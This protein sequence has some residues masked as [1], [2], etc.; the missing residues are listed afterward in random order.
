VPRR[1]LLLLGADN[2]DA[3]A[4]K[5][6]AR[7]KV[8][9]FGLSD[10]CDWRGYDLQVS[11]LSTRFGVRRSGQTIGTFE[12]PLLG[13]YN[14]RNALA[15]MAVGAAVGLS[16]ETMADGLRAFKGVRRRLQLRGIADGVS[17]YDDFAHH[18]TAI[19][20]TLQGVRSAYPDRRIWAIFEPRSATSC[21]RVF[22]S[23]FASALARADR[24]VLPAVYRSTLPDDQRL[25][26]EALV[27][28]LQAA[29]VDARYIPDV[30]DIVRAVSKDAQRGDLVIVMSNGGFDSIHDK[31]L[32]AL[33]TR[34]T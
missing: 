12:I 5:A 16:P 23:D 14:V 1:G 30:P 2:P 11:A 34:A 18:P 6:S 24:V 7:G 10:G 19:A 29:G 32:S 25:S 8:E 27:N 17:V 22:Q 21:R 9:T 20:E 4:L 26:A 13:A 31:L 15:A 3:L 33:E 28:D